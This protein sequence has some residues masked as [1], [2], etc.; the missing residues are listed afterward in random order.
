M[1]WA[2][3][4][5]AFKWCKKGFGSR[6]LA[7][8]EELLDPL[9]FLRREFGRHLLELL[10][11]SEVPSEPFNDQGG[12]LDRREQLPRIRGGFFED[13]IEGVYLAPER[14]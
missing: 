5:A 2:P 10:P 1:P 3:V 13:A 14:E 4:F 6:N 7:V 9:P 8:Q 11:V 12:A